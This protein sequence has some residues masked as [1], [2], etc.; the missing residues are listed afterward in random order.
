M[1]LNLS[2]IRT[3]F[4]ISGRR[5]YGQEAISQLEHALQC[6]SLAE[7]ADETSETI[8]AALLHDLGHMID[9]EHASDLP[10]TEASDDL[11]QYLAL[12]FLKGLLPESALAPIRMHVDA[13]RY[14]CGFEAGYWESLS[15]ASK[16]S[17]ELQGGAFSQAQA[18]A[19]LKKDFAAEAIRLRRYDDLAKLP[20]KVTPPLGHFLDLICQVRDQ[21]CHQNFTIAMQQSA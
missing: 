19:F 14:L 18:R 21:H 9:A 13:K 15:N 16:R 12:P 11:H 1:S 2:D 17:L 20:H 4:Q 6:A 7:Q 8:V 10:V 5:V 3:L